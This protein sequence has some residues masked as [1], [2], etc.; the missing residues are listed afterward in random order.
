M[1]T[2]NLMEN[3]LVQ[4]EKKNYGDLF[5]QHLFDQYRHYVESAEKIS[6]RRV[7]AHNFFLTVNSFLTALYGILKNFGMNL[8][9][10]RL[11]TIIGI[12]ASFTWLFVI[13]S[14]RDLNT[15]K[16]EVIHELENYMPAALYHYEWQKAQHGKRQTYKPTSHIEKYVPIIF[17]VLYMTLLLISFL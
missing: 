15:V 1:D 11:L 8:W 13:R 12:L 2:G 9:G 5:S 17:I 10:T 7:T 3:K 6:E 14:Y 4:I 16:F